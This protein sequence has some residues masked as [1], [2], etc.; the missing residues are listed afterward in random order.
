[1]TGMIE[2]LQRELGA[3]Q[4]A[5]LLRTPLC[6]DS[7]Q[8]PLCRVNGRQM[9]LFC[10]NNY[11]SIA[12]HPAIKKAVCQA[13][14]KYGFGAGASRLIAGTSPLHL[15]AERRLAQ[16]FRKEAALIFPSGYS[17]NESLL[18]TLPQAGDLVL[19]DKLDHASIIDALRSSQAR[20][21]TYRRGN[22]ERLEN[23]LALNGYNNKYIVTESIFSMDGDRA[24]LAELVRLKHKYGA[25][26]IVDE[27][28]AIGCM[29]KNGAGLCEELGVLDE[30]D[31][32]VGTMSKALGATGG[33][34]AAP[35]VV[36]EYLINKARSFIYTTAPSHANC[37]AVLAGLAII[38]QEPQRRKMLD[39][40]ARYLV[41]KLRYRHIIHAPAQIPSHIVP[42]IIGGEKETLHAAAMLFDK[43]FFISAIRP[44]TVAPGTSRLRISLQAEHTREQIDALCE[45][46]ET[47]QRPAT[48][49]RIELISGSGK[50]VP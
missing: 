46:L 15:E 22:Y 30:T 9:V 24:D 33:V 5:N 1:M 13:V 45:V 44:P 43:G 40:N 41:E 29:G 2:S 4:E 7:A 39:Y 38:A 26:L 16:L 8:G 14:E 36:R 23:M 27:A 10:S 48:K 6:I 20:F 3:L 11:L 32:V 47:I 12:D 31:I 42:V 49:Q 21:N 19:I 37:A 18:R 28:H 50:A 35:A 34:V 17:A 25:I